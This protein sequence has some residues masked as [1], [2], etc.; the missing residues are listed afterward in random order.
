MQGSL[1]GVDEMIPGGRL[2]D[3][4]LNLEASWAK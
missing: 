4:Q 1:S 2:P 3:H